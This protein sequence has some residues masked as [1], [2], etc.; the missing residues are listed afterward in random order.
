MKEWKFERQ[1]HTFEEVPT[2]LHR[3][4]IADATKEISKAGNDMIKLE[5]EV[6]GGTARLWHYT[7]FLDDRPEIT[8]SM[9]T[10]L[11]DSFGISDGDFNL[12]NWTG[13]V[14]GCMVK[15][16]EDD[17]SK[18]AYFINKEKQKDLPAWKESNGAPG[19]GAKEVEVDE[20]N[21]PF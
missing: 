13:K 8:N 9:L 12:K 11:F 19:K 10:A 15:K 3:V 18:V 2:G 17:R 6:S 21:L 16:D 7:V 14:G 5:F 1:E 20:G 4:R